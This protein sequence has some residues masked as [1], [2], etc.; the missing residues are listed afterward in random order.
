MRAFDIAS[1][2]QGIVSQDTVSQDTVSRHTVSQ[3][4][5]WR[6]REATLAL[7]HEPTGAQHRKQLDLLA[8][9]PAVTVAILPRGPG[10]E[11]PSGRG[12]SLRGNDNFPRIRGTGLSPSRSAMAHGGPARLGRRL[13]ARSRFQCEPTEYANGAV[14]ATW[15]VPSGSVVR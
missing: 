10:Y 8:R 1:V 4:T 9:A 14:N 3:R 6:L 7:E 13:A 2:S 5:W 12:C 11:R 15:T